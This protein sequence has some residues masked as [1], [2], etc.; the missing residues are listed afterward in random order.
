MSKICPISHSI[1]LYLDCLECDNKICK[2]HK[3]VLRMA[4][5]SVKGNDKMIIK[6]G[7]IVKVTN[8]NTTTF[9]Y[10]GKYKSKR[11]LYELNYNKSKFYL[12]NDDFLSSFKTIELGKILVSLANFK[13][14]KVTNKNIKITELR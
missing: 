11:L 13:R 10:C 14:N 9:L 4:K 6:R 2:Q 8:N 5:Y 3:T 7:Q 12:V 1:V